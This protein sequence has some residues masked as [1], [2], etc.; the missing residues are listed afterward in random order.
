[1]NG[2]LVEYERVLD[3]NAGEIGALKEKAATAEQNLAI[4]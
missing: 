4:V 3:Q 1:M 2:Q